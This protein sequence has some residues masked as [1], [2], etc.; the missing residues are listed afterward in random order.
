MRKGWEGKGPLAEIEAGVTSGTSEAD[1]RGRLV[2]HC[3]I[4]LKRCGGRYITAHIV[5]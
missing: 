4:W 3:G 1:V 2:V 5:F